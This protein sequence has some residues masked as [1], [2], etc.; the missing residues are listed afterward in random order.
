MWRNTGIILI[1]EGKV[2]VKVTLQQATKAQMGRGS[3][4]ILFF[5][6]SALDGMD[7]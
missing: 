6:T 4:P 5:L 1:D 7:S 2:G 3:I